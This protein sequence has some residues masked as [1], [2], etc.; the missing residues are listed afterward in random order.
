MNFRDNKGITLVAE[1]ITIILLL[2]IVSIITYSSKSTFQIRDL[3]NMY[4]D[5]VTLQER[6]QN[7]YL[8]YG[9]APIGDDVTSRVSVA[10]AVG[11]RFS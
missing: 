9:E 6:A 1:V 3:N 2:L 10:T 11:N 5:I 8:K 7:Y 4:A